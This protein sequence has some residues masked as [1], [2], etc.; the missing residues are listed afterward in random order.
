MRKVILISLTMALLLTGLL[1]NGCTKTETTLTAAE[2][3]NGKTIKMVVSSDPGSLGD[4]TSRV[5]A[6]YLGAD[7]K[8]NVT[9]ENMREA[10]GLEGINYL[11]EANPDGLTIGTISAVKFLSNKILNDPAVTCEIEDFSCLFKVD[12]G[13]TYFFVSS[14]GPFQSVED[15]RAGKDMLLAAGSASGYITLAGLSVVDLLDL[16]AKVVTGFENNTARSLATQRGEVIGYAISLGAV[17]ADLE[18]GTLKPLFVLATKRD[19]VSPDIPAITELANLSESDI[20]L[21]KLWENGLASGTMMATPAGISKDKL[22]YLN[23]LADRWC[24]NEIFLQEIDQVSGYHVS[25][26]P[27]GNDLM[28]SILDMATDLES[29]QTRFT[30][31]IEKYRF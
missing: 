25:E 23:S 13:Q 11:A 29:F 5:V 16:D 19:P 6:N 1:I 21:V 4:L 3:Y 15:L 12:N 18:A 28:A 22:N 20:A 17:K 24:Q 14:S 8:G 10:G 26:Y 2:F 30:E 31:M 7:I 9:V 27:R